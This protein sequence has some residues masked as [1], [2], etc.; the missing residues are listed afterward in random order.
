MENVAARVA[1]VEMPSRREIR[2]KNLFSVTSCKLHWHPNGKYLCV[3]VVRHSKSKKTFYTNFELFRVTE[4]LV[5]V[6]MME[7][8]DTVVAF[9]WEPTGDRF[10]LCHGEGNLKLDVSFY[11]MC[12]GKA[13]NE[14]EKLYTL[15]GKSA[16]HLFWSPMGN[17]VILA[18]LG[19]GMNGVLEFWDCDNRCSLKE[20]EHYKCTRV[21]WDPS[22]RMV[23]TSVSQPL[24]NFNY[25]YQMDNGFKIW[26]FQ[27]Q[28]L[29][30]DKKD[31]LFQM[32]WRPRPKSLLTA[33][34]KS[35][36]VRNIKQYE[37]K[38]TEGDRAATRAAQAA[39]KER[40]NAVALEFRKLLDQRREEYMQMYHPKIVKLQDGQDHLKNDGYEVIETVDEQEIEV[41]EQPMK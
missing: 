14:L 25:K 24:E 5:P 15:E 19:D 12:G 13:K 21:E 41:H 38:Y 22:G 33:D 23:A 36:I 8:K 17:L 26:S 28:L 9:A 4:D 31:K 18:G 7:M 1:L 35:K 39:E 20:Q 34:E 6:E 2:Q 10:A 30:E 16:N 40:K 3:K 37:R 11:T 32:M 29:K 27:G